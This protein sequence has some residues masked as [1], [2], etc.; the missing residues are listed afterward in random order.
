MSEL[1]DNQIRKAKQNGR[2]IGRK[3]AFDEVVAD[4]MESMLMKMEKPH[5]R[6]SY[7]K[8]KVPF[9]TVNW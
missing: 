2:K 9:S 1:V 7:K 4:S 8:I 5:E 6:I 3:E